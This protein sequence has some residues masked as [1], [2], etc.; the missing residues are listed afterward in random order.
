MF[1]ESQITVPQSFK[2]QKKIGIVFILYLPIPTSGLVMSC[3]PTNSQMDVV[4]AAVVVREQKTWSHR[5][6]HL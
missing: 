2:I 5:G 4:A 1:Y 3:V 6:V